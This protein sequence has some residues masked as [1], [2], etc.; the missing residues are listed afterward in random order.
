[1]GSLRDAYG[2]T[3][4]GMLLVAA[5]LTLSGLLVISIE[6]RA[7]RHEARELMPDTA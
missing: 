1:M 7:R 2:N 3:G 4:V 6:A 5:S